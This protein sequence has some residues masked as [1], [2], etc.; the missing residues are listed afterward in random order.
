MFLLAVGLPMLTDLYHQVSGITLIALL[1]M[2]G[3]LSLV[4]ARFILTSYLMSPSKKDPTGPRPSNWP[5]VRLAP[6][7]P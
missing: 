6:S 1:G 5:P 7:L 3:L 4:P 2:L